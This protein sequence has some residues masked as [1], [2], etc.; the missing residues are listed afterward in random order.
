VRWS[1]RI[2]TEA[3]YPSR[4]R[5][6]FTQDRFDTRASPGKRFKR[7]RQRLFL[8]YERLNGVDLH[9]KG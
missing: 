8:A 4:K 2:N 6:S 5:T 1:T 3:L 9:S 7:W